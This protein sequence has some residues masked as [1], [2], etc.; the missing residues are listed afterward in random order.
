MGHE[1][2]NDINIVQSFVNGNAGQIKGG[3]VYW[4]RDSRAGPWMYVWSDQENRLNAYHFD[5]NAQP[6]PMFDTT[7]VSQSILES[8]GG[9][10]GGV[11]TLSAN[12]SE[13]GSGI[14]W[15]SMAYSGS[16]PNSGVHPG[17]LRALNADD[18]SQE[19]WNSEQDSARDS[20]GNWPKF[21]PPTVVDGR[22]YM[23]SFPLDGKSNAPFNVYGLSP[24]FTLAATPPNPGVGPGGSVGYTVATGALNGFS[25][26]VHLSVDGLP[27]HGSATFAA[28][29]FATP[30]TTTLTVQTADD[31]PPGSNMLTITG[32]SGSVSHSTSVGLLV[33][34]VV[35]GTGSIS[36]D[37][38]GSGTPM[39]ATETAGVVP[40]PNWNEASGVSGNVA[41][42]DETGTTT[43]ASVTWTADAAHALGIADS[44]GDFRMMDGYL[45]SDGSNTSIVVSGLPYDSAGYYVYVYSDGAN[46]L[47][48]PTGNYRLTDATTQTTIDI[49]DMTASNFNGS[50]VRADNTAGNYAVFF[51]NDTGFTL[52]AIPGIVRGQSV[53]G[54]QHAPLNGIQ[55]VHGDR[56]FANGFD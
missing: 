46:D 45:D 35:P 47:S 23:A 25:D 26:P 44:P 4:N 12:G 3:P 22:V 43:L 21:S 36:M 24:D 38:V 39:A 33:T 28:N 54:I 5:V 37:F 8:N 11:L 49:T 53:N 34:R 15:S 14:V 51:T 31:T 17:V 10:A 9:S 48:S 18:L 40:K 42:V 1:S 6:E 50:Y 29:D 7:P 16:N 2:A 41:L 13:A 30:G 19:L 56:I 27:A 55:I 52:T 20:M 32:V